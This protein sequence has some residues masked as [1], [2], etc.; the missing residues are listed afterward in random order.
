MSS[1]FD[2]P[3]THFFT[4]L[5]ARDFIRE[6]Y[7]CFPD[8]PVATLVDSVLEVVPSRKGAISKLYNI[9]FS[10][11]REPTDDICGAW[12]SDLQIDIDDAMWQ[13]ILRRVHSSSTCAFNVK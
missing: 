9:L 12:S 6:N 11:S 3:R 8:I 13:S 1:H 10:N 7:P 4:Y 5:Q 2:L